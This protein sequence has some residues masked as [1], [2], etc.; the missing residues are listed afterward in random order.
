MKIKRNNLKRLIESILNEDNEGNYSESQEMDVSTIDMKDIEDLAASIFDKLDKFKDITGKL[1]LTDGSGGGV[2]RYLGKYEKASKLLDTKSG[3]TRMADAIFHYAKESVDVIPTRGQL[4]KLKSLAEQLL[5][6]LGELPLLG[7][8]ADK[9]F[10]MHGLGGFASQPGISKEEYNEMKTIL[11]EVKQSL[12]GIINRINRASPD[13][14]TSDEPDADLGQSEQKPSD[15]EQ[16]KQDK[17]EAAKKKEK[18][19]SRHPAEM[20]A[21]WQELVKLDK[22]I[23]NKFGDSGSY[24]SWQRWYMTA[25]KDP[26]AFE[27]LGI[28]KKKYLQ[29]KETLAL[30]DILLK[31][32]KGTLE[33]RLMR[34]WFSVL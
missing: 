34:K 14:S 5:K 12:R 22:D 18:G 9:M 33:E 30:L 6:K 4:A 1:K 26:E 11:K 17:P 28:P 20:K 29:A 31:S 10:G 25:T 19:W 24:G 27:A 16:D 7:G 23:A 8:T 13:L 15:F 3:Y 2:A 21:K 32:N